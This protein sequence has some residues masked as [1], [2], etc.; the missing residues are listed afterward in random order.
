[1]PKVNVSLNGR[2]YAVSCDEGQESRVLELGAMVDKKMR[3]IAKTGAARS[4]SYLLV[5]T[6]LMLADEL[7]EAKEGSQKAAASAEETAK[8][9]RLTK[10]REIDAAALD[11][12]T[13][14]IE[15]MAG[16]LAG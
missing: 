3:A 9:D 11:H 8:A 6:T 12:L 5:L 13:K 10:Q 4:E 2:A 16:K 1:M 15:R 7:V 14:R